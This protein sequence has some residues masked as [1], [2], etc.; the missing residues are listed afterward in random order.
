M[1]RLFPPFQPQCFTT[2]LVYLWHEGTF[3]HS[4][5]GLYEIIT[6]S[7]VSF[8]FPKERL[9][10]ISH[11]VL[12]CLFVFI[13]FFILIPAVLTKEFNKWSWTSGFFLFVCLFARNQ[14]DLEVIEFFLWSSSKVFLI[15]FFFFCTEANFLC[16]SS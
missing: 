14:G 10:T 2:G 3:W 7:G 8:C 13:L 5:F 4:E 16:L 12:V 11:L 6:E 15:C 9:C 1:I